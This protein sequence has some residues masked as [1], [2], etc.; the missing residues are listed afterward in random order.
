MKL[1][2]LLLILSLNIQGKGLD[3][4]LDL[5]ISNCEK[6][7]ELAPEK[8][9]EKTQYGERYISNN[10]DT[11][12]YAT[13]LKVCKNRKLFLSRLFGEK[14]CENFL[15]GDANSIWRGNILKECKE[16]DIKGKG[17]IFRQC[18]SK[19]IASKKAIRL[20]WCTAIINLG[21]SYLKV[22][23]ECLAKVKTGDCLTELKNGEMKYYKCFMRKMGQ[24][25]ASLEKDV[26]GL[27]KR[28]YKNCSINDDGIWCDGKQVQV[29]KKDK[30]GNTI[31]TETKEK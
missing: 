29:F 13:D 8:C 11:D 9:V 5:D 24:F 1:I 27:K 2:L 26:S 25:R 20:D 4:V 15:M 23:E 10:I 18:L 16:F 14:T 6:Q 28:T 31:G 21:P 17:D 12:Y 7:G 3:A 22:T 19:K 30:S